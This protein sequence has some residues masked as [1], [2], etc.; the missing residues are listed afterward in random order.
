MLLTAVLLKAESFAEM[1]PLKG[2]CHNKMYTMTGYT[3]EQINCDDN[4]AYE[5]TKSAKKDYLVEIKRHMLKA[6]V[7]HKEGGKYIHKV[8]NDRSYHRV[9][10]DPN[11]IY[12][13]ERYYRKNKSLPGLRHMVVKIKNA[14]KLCYEKYF[15]I[16]YS[17]CEEIDH[18]CCIQKYF[19]MVTP[20]RRNILIP[21]HRNMC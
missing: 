9:V 6:S 13:I 21:V 2:I 19:H 11:E 3:I 14:T 17:I 1:Q 7:A 8:R 15:C 5:D 4:G 16:L 20:R 10:V 18:K 12:M